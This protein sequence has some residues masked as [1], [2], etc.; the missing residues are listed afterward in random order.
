MQMMPF[1]P[2]CRLLSILRSLRST[3]QSRNDLI[4]ENLALRQQLAILRQSN[5]RPKLSWPDRL[6]WICLHR[7][8]PKWTTA[9]TI[10]KP[11]T[12]IR[13][14]RKGFRLYWRLK[15]ISGK[16]KGRPPI[17]KEIRQ[18][19]DRMI[20][21]NPTWGAPRIHGELLM[22][23]IAVSERTVSRRL[24]KKAPDKNRAQN[25]LTFLK[26][27]RQ[28]IAAMDFFTVPTAT[29]KI[30]YVFFVIHHGRRA[31][32]HFNVTLHPTSDWVKQQLREAFPFERAPKYLI[33]DRDSIFSREVVATI[34][35]LGISPV[36]TSYRSP[37]QNGVAERWVG[38]CR[39]EL[40]DHA[41][42]FNENHLRRLLKKYVAYYNEDRCHCGLQKDTPSERPVQIRPH[43]RA[44][45][46][47]LDK[48]GGLHHRYEWQKAA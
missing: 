19:I 11:E 28:S 39:R 14:H 24:P 34:K 4:L 12:V 46:I 21:E 48:V 27:H 31:I 26:N 37:W 1:R 44:Q 17:A 23:G 36:R 20:A 15:S 3:L 43:G 47:S 42:V 5:P 6:F 8:W 45:V 30:L 16:K 33:F 18:L 40:L 10:V 13:W 7:I 41:I 29:F 22:L 32:L 38:S 35:S 2:F 9:L 25:W